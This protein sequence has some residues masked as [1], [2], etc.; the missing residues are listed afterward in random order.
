MHAAQHAVTDDLLHFTHST[1]VAPVC[2][3]NVIPDIE[4]EDVASTTNRL[5]SRKYATGQRPNEA[6]RAQTVESSRLIALSLER[7]NELADKQTD[8]VAYKQE[9]CET[10]EDLQDPTE[11]LQLLRTERLIELKA[12]FAGSKIGMRRLCVDLE[13]SSA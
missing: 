6:Y 3:K 10:P 8:V 1:N 2:D 13:T 12:R 5:N 7:L 9:D 4:Q 11:Y